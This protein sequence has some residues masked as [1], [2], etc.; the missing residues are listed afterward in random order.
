M[1]IVQAAGWYLP[2]TLGGTELYVASLASHLIAAGPEV[3]VAAPDP[4]AQDV[5]E[6]WHYQVPVFRY[7]IAADVTRDQARGVAIVPGAERL[8]DWLARVRPDVVHFHT[9]V[10]G[11]GLHEV[12]AAR[13]IGARVV[14]TSHAASLGFLCERGTLMRDGADLCDGNVAE[15]V[16]ASCALQVRGVPLPALWGHAPRWLAHAWLRWHT[17]RCM[18]CSSRRSASTSSCTTPSREN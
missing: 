5:R 18:P 10:T 14:V 7:P 9:F 16:C 3:L 2:D 17:W 13:R 4:G 15:A 12:R 11:L 1:R 6:Y 8:H